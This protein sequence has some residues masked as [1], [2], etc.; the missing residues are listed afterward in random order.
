MRWQWL[1]TIMCVTY[2]QKKKKK[3]KKKKT[4]S[5]FTLAIIEKR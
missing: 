4:D 1:T 3:K 5:N 2:V